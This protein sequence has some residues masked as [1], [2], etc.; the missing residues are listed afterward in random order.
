MAKVSQPHGGGGESPE[1]RSFKRWL[2]AQPQLFGLSAEVRG[3]EEADLDSGDTIDVLYKTARRTVGVEAKS[4]LSA[5]GDLLRG[6]FQ[7][8]KYAA[9]LRAMARWK[10]ERAPCAVY[11]ALEASATPLL[12]ETAGVLG[13]A[14][15]ENAREANTREA[16]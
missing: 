8:V 10:G 3:E 15:V 7:C 1:H 4:R 14:L 11:L 2:A 13:V 16:V 6:V 12:R 5:E 9:V